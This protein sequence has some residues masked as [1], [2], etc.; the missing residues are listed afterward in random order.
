MSTSLGNCA[1]PPCTCEVQESTAVI[2]NGQSYCSDACATGHPN[3]EPCHS[4]GSCGCTCA[5]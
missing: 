3:G 2:R 4:T 1:C 5:S